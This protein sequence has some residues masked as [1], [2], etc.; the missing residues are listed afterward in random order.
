MIAETADQFSAA[1][2]YRVD[3]RSR[4]IWQHMPLAIRWSS[5][6]F[7]DAL[8]NL[9]SLFKNVSARL[10]NVS[11]LTTIEQ[12]HPQLFLERCTG[13][14]TEVAM[15]GFSVGAPDRLTAST[16]LK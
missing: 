15:W 8:Q 16:V 7:V 4:L 9:T 5:H 12:P 11:V 3:A 1:R 2:S 6:A 10:V 13:G 14:S